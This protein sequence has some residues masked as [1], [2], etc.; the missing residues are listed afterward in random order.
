[1]GTR[2]ARLRRPIAGYFRRSY[3]TDQDSSAPTSLVRSG[4]G[5][6]MKTPILG[7]VGGQTTSGNTGFSAWAAT[8]I[9]GSMPFGRGRPRITTPTAPLEIRNH[10]RRSNARDSHL[11][12]HVWQRAGRDHPLAP[13][14]H[15]QLES[16][17]AKRSATPSWLRSTRLAGQQ[18]LG[19]TRPVPEQAGRRT[20]RELRPD[21]GREVPQPVAEEMRRGE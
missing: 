1:M 21:I 7:V 17:S 10:R 13:W 19:V 8:I 12:Q 16:T 6:P 11:E 14:L 15:M 20:G 4:Y 2:V 3:C 5:S 18:D 9:T